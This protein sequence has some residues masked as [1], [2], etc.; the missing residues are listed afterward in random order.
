[1][2]NTTKRLV[3]SSILT[4]FCEEDGKDS[5]IDG[6][7]AGN[8]GIIEQN[9]RI[10]EICNFDA[11]IS[12]SPTGREYIKRENFEKIG[13]I[14]SRSINAPSGAI[15]H[16][17]H[18]IYRNPAVEESLKLGQTL[19]LLQVP[20]HGVEWT[21][22]ERKQMSATFHH[23]GSVYYKQVEQARIANTVKN[24]LNVCLS[25]RKDAVIFFNGGANHT[26][27]LAA[28]LLLAIQKL[29]MDVKYDIQIMP[30]KLFSEYVIDGI[31]GVRR[32]ED[33]TRV[34]DPFTVEEM[35]RYVPCPDIICREDS[36]TG[37]LKALEFDR[38]MA[39]AI[40]HVSG[41]LVFTVP[42]L[43]DKVIATI[44]DLGGTIWNQVATQILIDSN[45]L[46]KDIRDQLGISRKLLTLPIDRLLKEEFL[47]RFD[48]ITV[49]QQQ[50]GN[51]LLV[52]YPNNREKLIDATVNNWTQAKQDYKEQ[53]LVANE[54]AARSISR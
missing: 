14:L 49:E 45:A 46:K 54:K 29:P 50:P 31:E 26:H 44:K 38:I 34:S 35:Y 32:V 19:K 23:E 53:Y 20:Y 51:K 36:E 21:I 11:I 52:T 39:S 41:E 22:E 24:L 4:S 3:N 27:R 8:I 47:H 28:N 43:D 48:D 1:M 15:D 2:H 6:R 13:E 40:K 25:Q 16:L 7:I 17:A 30:M 37:E 12:V 42:A 33:E 5:T 9:K 10:R 18:Q